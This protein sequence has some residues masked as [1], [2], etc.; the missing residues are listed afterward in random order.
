MRSKNALRNIVTNLLLQ[1]VVIVYGFIIPK[2][3][4]DQFGSDVNGLVVS[5]TQFLSYITF[6]ESGFGAVVKAV[7]YKP[8]A[9]KD[10]DAIASIIKTSEK[11]FRRIALFF[12]VYILILCIV[13]PL[14]TK[15]DFEV[16]FTISLIIVIAISTF[17]EY[18]FGMAYRLFLQAE[19]KIYVVSIIQILTYVL[20]IAVVVVCAMMGVGI[21]LLELLLGLIFT[22]RPILQNL[23]VKKR[24]NISLKDASDKYPIKQKWDGLAQHIAW[25]I[26]ENTDVVVLT[27]FTNLAEVSVYSV[28]H[29]ITV[30]MRKIVYAFN[31]GID[32][33]FGDMIAKNEEV[34]LR[35]KFALY[36]VLY[37]MIITILFVST[38]LLAIPFVSVYTRGVTDADYFRPLFGYLLVLGKFIWAIR[39]PYNSLIHAAGHFKETRKG[40]WLE[41]VV[42]IVLSIILVFNYGIVG[43]A[44]GTAVAMLIRTVEFIF[45]ANK[46]ILHRSVKNSVGKILVAVSITIIAS[47]IRFNI[48]QIDLPTNYLGWIIEAIIVLLSVSII[49]ILSYLVLYK[50]DMKDVL[51]FSKK[52]LKKR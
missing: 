14:I 28:Y 12:I 29:L 19:Q 42:N 43:V 52:I 13:F 38:L 23:Y 41:A 6:F 35:R 34:N 26:H 8:I 31:N 4:I 45:H 10:K 30:A 39:L 7:F 33:S 17:S 27:I 24:Y 22:L 48:V 25:M 18:F 2:V 47:I 37:I 36:E 44:I 40:A 21:I 49:T 11:F 9:K 5:I 50:K 1:F 16:V 15:A 46:Y 32:S 20:G 51:A 3:I